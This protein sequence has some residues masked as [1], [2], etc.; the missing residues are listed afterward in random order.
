LNKAFFSFSFHQK[1][2]GEIFVARERKSPCACGYFLF[3]FSFLPFP[4]KLH[5][6]LLDTYIAYPNF[7]Q[8]EISEQRERKKKN[9]KPP[10]HITI[11]QSPRKGKNSAPRAGRCRKRSDVSRKMRR[12]LV[13][14]FFALCVHFVSPV[15]VLY[16]LLS[17]RR[18][19]DLFFFCLL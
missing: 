10:L 7:P 12:L 8:R 17:L 9:K 3:F 18:H 19:S 16:F 14:R 11:K 6:L 13:L 4:Q 15:F 1:D 2:F 5:F